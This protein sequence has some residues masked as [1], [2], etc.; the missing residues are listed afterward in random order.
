MPRFSLVVPTL[1][2]SDTLRHALAT[3]V[4][5]TYDDFEIVVQNNGNDSATEAVVKEFNDS[6]IRQFS[7]TSIL[8]MTEN[9]EAALNNA[10][11]DFIAFIGDDDGFFPDACELAAQIIASTNM[12]IVNWLPYCYYWPNYIELALRNRLV[13]LIDADVHVQMLSS[14]NHLKRFYRFAI[15]YSRLPMIYNS[16]IGRSVVEKAK[17]A[18]GR[19]F[20]GHAPDV[21]SGIVNAVHSSQFARIS[22]PLSMTGLSG[23]SV[24][25]NT[26][27]GRAPPPAERIERDFGTIRTD[28]RLPFARNLQIL[29]ANEMLLAHAQLSLTDR[30]IEPDFRGLVES[31]AATIN[32]PFGAYQKNLAAIH[33]L[34]GRHGIALDEITI[35]APIENRPTVAPGTVILSDSRK[36]MVIDGD[37]AG[38]T[39]IA[40]AIR[41]LK[42]LMPQVQQG[43][44]IEIR[45]DSASDHAVV[46]PGERLTFALGGNGLAGLASGWGDPE[47][48]GSWSVT[49][50]AVLRVLL[51]TKDSLPL[52]AELK[53]LPFIGPG[54]PE[55]DVVCRARGKEIARWN[56]PSAEWQIRAFTI[57]SDLV[58]SDGIVDLEFLI[59]HPRSPAELGMSADTRQLGIGVEWLAVVT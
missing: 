39:N 8:K 58:G 32:E 37:Q 50:R 33:E 38:L 40:D 27:Y 23:H 6:R 56:C 54:H 4:V 59:C 31:L 13:A 51:V 29:L 17:T 25:R 16:F 36:M 2:R 30:H 18:A 42:P 24:G 49:K 20:F 11:G 53:F 10:R 45:P 41:W 48:W 57:S 34:A 12:E 9:W 3:L 21:T 7:S 15:D 55:I 47:A 5:Q 46:G 26:W 19:Y 35:P 52:H 43:H 22:R 1:K 44:M 28:E 14:D